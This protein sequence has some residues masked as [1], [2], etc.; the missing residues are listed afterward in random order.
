[1]SFDRN[2][3]DIP[4]EFSVN[5]DQNFSRYIFRIFG[6]L[7][8]EFRRFLIGFFTVI[9]MTRGD[10]CGLWSA[11]RG[12]VVWHHSCSGRGDSLELFF[13]LMGE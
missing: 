10:S 1:M 6:D 2:I 9:G 13:S 12:G 7:W 4:S 3:G 5:S 11:S 8:P